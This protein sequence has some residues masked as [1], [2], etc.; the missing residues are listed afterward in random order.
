MQQAVAMGLGGGCVMVVFFSFWSRAYG[1]THLGRIQ[2]AAQ[3]LTVLA[4]AVGPLLL[5]YCVERTGSYG[6]AF[7]VLSL[8]V[9][10]LAVIA[11]LVPLPAGADVGMRPRTT[12]LG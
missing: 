4:S 8:T 12:P 3:A 11:S 7:Y 6:F 9:T 5:A 1:R 2:G 10:L